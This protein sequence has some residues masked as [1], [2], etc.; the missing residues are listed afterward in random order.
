MWGFL[1]KTRTK[2]LCIFTE[3]AN[4]YDVIRLSVV[5]TGV[6]YGEESGFKS[7]KHSVKS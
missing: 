2:I 4:F 6:L 7:F 1:D 3:T 5:L